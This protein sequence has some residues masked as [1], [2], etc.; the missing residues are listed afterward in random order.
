MEESD[1]KLQYERIEKSY[2][3]IGTLLSM[4]E[5]EVFSRKNETKIYNET[6]GECIFAF[7][8]ITPE[9]MSTLEYIER[10]LVNV[11]YRLGCGGTPDG[12]VLI[13]NLEMPL[14]KKVE[15]DFCED[16]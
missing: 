14:A 7:P 9:D 4:I 15:I 1:K 3:L 10:H 13:A 8:P 5:M 16:E 11:G 2:S 6:T 12:Y